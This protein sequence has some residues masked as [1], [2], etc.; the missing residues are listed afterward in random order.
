[1]AMNMDAVLNVKARVDGSNKIVELNRGLMAVGTT[2]K[3]VTGAMRGL[4]GAAG[5][6]SGALGAL[7]P[8]A[9][10]AGLVGLAKG[11]L[12][13]GDK[14]NDLSQSTG[15][16]VEALAKFKKAAATS[17]TDI[18]AVAKGLV[19]LSKGMLEA[20]LGSKL[21][22]G[23]FKALGINVKDS[24]GQ[25]KSADAVMLEVANRFKAMPDGVAKTALSLKLFGKAG[26]E[27]I[28]LLNMGGDAIDKLSVKMTTAFAQKADEYNDKL[29]ML[30]G[31]VGALG[32]DLLI[33][34][35][36]ALDKITDAVSGAIT[37]FNNLPQPVKNFAVAGAAVAIA[38]GPAT[39]LIRGAIGIFALF[40][41]SA[42]AAGVAAAGAAPRVAALKSALG[43]LL[44]FGLITLAIDVV[45]NGMSKLVDL[46]ARLGKITGK[47]TGNY[48]SDL[49]GKAASREKLTGELAKVRAQQK[50]FER[51]ARSVRFPMLTGQDEAARAGLLVAKTREAKLLSQIPRARLASQI[52]A[53]SGGFSPD[54][55]AMKTGGGGEAKKKGKTG[56]DKEAREAKRLA[57]EQAKQLLDSQKGL[58]I[59]EAELRIARAINPLDKA[60][61]EYALQKL[62]VEQ[63]FAVKL[64]DTKQLK[65]GLAKQ[66][67]INNLELVKRNDLEI[68]RLDY[69]EQQT[70]ELLKQAGIDNPDFGKKPTGINWEDAVKFKPKGDDQGKIDEEYAKIEQRL[71]DLINP[72]NQIIAAANA[73]GD[74]FANSFEGMITGATTAREAL[75]NL[76]QSI[77]SHFT[78]MATQMIA[79]AVKMMAIKLI[80]QLVGS[81]LG[82]FA[83]GG[84]T[85]VGKNFDSAGAGST[86]ISWSDAVKYTP[87]A[88]GNVFAA[89]GIQRFAM[90]GIVNSPTLFKFAN[91]GAMQ[92]GLMG[93]AGPEAIM[94]LQR[95]AD[96]KLGV[97]V[98]GGRESAMAR[99]RPT[100]ASGQA[101]ADGSIDGSGNGNDNAGAVDVRY[102]VERINSVDYVTADQFQQGMKQAASQGAAQGE[103]RTLRRLQQS[104]STRRRI[105]M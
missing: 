11:A 90:G 64:A 92:N 76:F 94:P 22:A 27:M 56:A 79:D 24:S 14:M 60:A 49:G 65:D 68:K 100:T 20:S 18:D 78:K 101:Q 102:T 48:F 25:L 62:R 67:I 71:K 4:T 72:A 51:E 9:S 105:G 17:G 47:S 88:N 32:A 19:K 52:P 7:A 66:E 99:Y 41:G 85:N 96:G 70:K 53:A 55:E 93:E 89:N 23:A 3:G 16:S 73:I 87:N 43:G 58:A 45:I 54:L 29:A 69:L 1:M 42:T 44:K 33:L 74:A 86:G 50:A 98:N 91:G 10:V 37:A 36:P 38:W 57:E 5:G 34:L 2:A 30:S 21:Q 80:T 59:S 83:G 15:V 103:Q 26:A 46:Q 35:L 82:G 81:V 13:A 28:P 12:D 8:L 97:A 63:D 6:L 95:G 61:A 104:P 84:T 77:A 40:S 75:R 39:S 31:K